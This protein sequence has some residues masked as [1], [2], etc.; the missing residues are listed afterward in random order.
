MVSNCAVLPYDPYSEYGTI[1]I[2]RITF[3]YN[4]MTLTDTLGR[5]IKLHILYK[6]KIH[7]FSVQLLYRRRGDFL[8]FVNDKLRVFYSKSFD[9]IFANNVIDINL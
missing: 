2:Y 9:I 7:F 8:V 1:K 6:K 3:S 4:N 5:Y